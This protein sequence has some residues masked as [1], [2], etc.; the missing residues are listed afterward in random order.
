MFIFLILGNNT[1]RFGWIFQDFCISDMLPDLKYGTMIK[2]KTELGTTGIC[3]LMEQ[4]EIQKTKLKERNIPFFGFNTPKAAQFTGVQE[5]S[6]RSWKHR[7]FELDYK[8]CFFRRLYIKHRNRWVQI[9]VFQDEE[10]GY[11]LYMH[12]ASKPLYNDNFILTLDP[13]NE[14]EFYGMGDYAPVK[15]WKGIKKILQLRAEN[16][17]YYATNFVG[18][19]VDDYMKNIK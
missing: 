11:Y 14:R 13:Q 2:W 7:D 19:I 17:C 15:I 3:T 9:E 5:W 10:R 8:N 4:S 6:G 16:R 12:F 18:E 1:D